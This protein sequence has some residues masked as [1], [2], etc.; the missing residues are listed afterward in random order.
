MTSMAEYIKRVVTTTIVEFAV[1]LTL[2]FGACWAEVMK[3]IRA[4]HQ[5]L[6]DLNKVERG[7]DAADDVIRLTVSDDEII[8]FYERSKVETYD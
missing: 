8:I 6:W 1:P 5:D 2:G 3:A 4:A 7:K